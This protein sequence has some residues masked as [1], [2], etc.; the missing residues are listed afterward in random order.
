[1]ADH[2]A[3]GTK[4][5]VERLR[6]PSHP[7]FG[8][9]EA[10]QKAQVFYDL[11]GFSDAPPSVAIEHW[12]YSGKSSSGLRALAALLHYGLLDEEGTGEDRRVRL[13]ELARAILSPD[14][15]EGDRQRALTTAALNPKIYRTLWDRYGPNLP[16][17]TNLS[18]AL[19]REYSFNQESVRSFIGDFRQTVDFAKLAKPN[20]L[21]VTDGDALAPLNLSATLHTDGPGPQPAKGQ[22]MPDIQR[23]DAKPLD[24]PI[25]LI[26]GGQATLRVPIPL[27]EEN[28]KHLTTMLTAMLGGMKPAI[29]TTPPTANEAG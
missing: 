1:M 8:L 6:S 3:T 25:P 24:L 13:S 2:A 19:V 9:P 12:G 14:V 18:F 29:V 15:S 26:G 17:D 10:I 28:Y 22:D 11:E 27:T 21:L 4:K 16:S 20:R 7:A 23:A 5:A